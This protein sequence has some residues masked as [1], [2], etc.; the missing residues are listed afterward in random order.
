MQD[1]NETIS[2]KIKNFAEKK[3]SS[4]RKNANIVF[5]LVLKSIKV[6]YRNSVIGAL[7]T[8]LNP[9]LNMIVMYLVFSFVLGYGDSPTYPLYIFCGN[10]LFS[11]L[12]ASTTQSLTSIVNNR[13]ILTKNKVSQF[14]FPVSHN[15]S[16]IVNFG[17]SSIA[18][19]GVM[20]VVSISSGVNYFTPRL[21][22]VLLMLPAMFLFSYGLSLVLASAYVF[23][24][25]IQHLYNVFLTLWTYL[26]PVF[27]TI[28][29]VENKTFTGE[30]FEDVGYI[31]NKLKDI[32]L[33]IMKA[34][35]MYQFIEYFR[36]IVFAF[37]TPLGGESFQSLGE[38]F[39]ALGILY[40]IGLAF[41]GVG[42][43][44][45]YLTRRK[46]IYYI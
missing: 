29:R 22:L 36:Y 6:Q 26:T 45:F 44:V 28:D 31:L 18:L 23:F 27:W 30:N 25:D 35:P 21:F 4:F 3:R 40:L 9:L 10:I 11:L 16:A 12:R 41:F 17:F 5:E 39:Q 46:F 2:I 33:V 42:T 15:I 37:K 7:W 38:S 32:L 14:V 13:G 8:V 19:L 43:L 24:R 1:A 20:A 34:N